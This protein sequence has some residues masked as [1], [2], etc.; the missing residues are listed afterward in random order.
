MKK[1]TLHI[2]LMNLPSKV[3]SKGKNQTNIFNIYNKGKGFNV[4]DAFLLRNSLC[5]EAC[6]CHSKTH[7]EV[8]LV[9]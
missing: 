9:M 7:L 6:L 4:V 1:G 5:N 8:N 3:S 2:H